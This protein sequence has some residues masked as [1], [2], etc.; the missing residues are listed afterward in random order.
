[1]PFILKA[2]KALN[3]RTTVVRI[4]LKST[5]LSLFGDTDSMRNEF[6]IR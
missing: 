2:G 3:E 6:V 4:Q 5:H 1:M